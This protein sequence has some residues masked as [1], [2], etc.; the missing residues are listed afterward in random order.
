MSA[1]VMF[2]I[3]NGCA[4]EPL[5]RFSR[6]AEQ[7]FTSGQAYKMMVQ[8]EA[9]RRTVE[10][11][12]KMWAM[13]TEFS[14]QVEHYG[15]HWSPEDW[16]SILMHAFGKEMRLLPGLDGSLV[17]VGLSS[18]TLSKRNMIKFI[19][20]IYAEGTQRGVKFA[21]DVANHAR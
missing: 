6:L 3:W 20:F 9:D 5:D 12:N 19:E 11:N 2:Y 13:L 21:D 18:S 15:H 4:M 8:E 1:P 7:S 16:K 14:E 17:P 10:Q